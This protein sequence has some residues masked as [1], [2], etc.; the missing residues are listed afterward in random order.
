MPDFEVTRHTKE[1]RLYLTRADLAELSGI[2][3]DRLGVSHVDRAPDRD[4]ALVRVCLLED[5]DG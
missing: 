1:S 3:V 2:P 4:D 5:C